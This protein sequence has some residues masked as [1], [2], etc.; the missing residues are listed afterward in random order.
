MIGGHRRRPRH[1]PAKCKYPVPDGERRGFASLDA[2]AAFLRRQ[3]GLAPGCQGEEGEETDV[4]M[5]YYSMPFTLFGKYY[6]GP[7]KFRGYVLGEVGI[8]F[9]RF[10][11][12]GST[13]WLSDN[14]AGFLA[15]LGL[16]GQFY[17][18]E[19]TFFNLAYTFSLWGNS[20]Y[21]DGFLHQIKLG[22]G[23]QYE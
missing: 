6:F 2:M 1:E 23:F 20:Y 15:G 12:S 10:E 4:S 3:I 13:L 17:V 21:Q 5:L 8:Q 18:Y 14:D 11:Y 7:A 16:G 9:S 22:I 19:K